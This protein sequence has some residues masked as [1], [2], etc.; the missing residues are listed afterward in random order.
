MHQKAH[1]QEDCRLEQPRAGSMTM[2]RNGV[3]TFDILDF[4]D[5]I[6]NVLTINSA[7]PDMV[8]DRKVEKVLFILY[9][10]MRSCKILTE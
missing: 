8:R 5:S 6:N 4:T 10:S 7:Y 3:F 2:P 9:F 1:S